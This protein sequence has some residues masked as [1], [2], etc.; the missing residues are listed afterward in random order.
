MYGEKIRVLLK[1][2]GEEPQVI[3]IEDT[4]EAKQ[5]LVGGYIEMACPPI[6]DD[7]AVII[8]NEEGK[9]LGLKPNVYLLTESGIPYDVVCGDF[10]IVDAPLESDD[11]GGLSDEQIAKY[12][13][14]YG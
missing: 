10:L 3:E 1:K 2:V 14:F 6:H 12:T 8:C 11:F 4:L 9:L 7:T 5:E 13:Q